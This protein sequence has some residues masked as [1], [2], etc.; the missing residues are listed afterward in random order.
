MEKID[1]KKVLKPLYSPPIGEFAVIEVPTMQFVK[2]DGEGD[3]NES[4]SYKSAVEWLYF[5]SYAMKFAAKG[6]LGKDYV[7]PPLE[8]LWWAADPKSFVRRDKVNGIGR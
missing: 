3:P 6:K 2:L 7:V 4:P 5:V 8:G 1:F